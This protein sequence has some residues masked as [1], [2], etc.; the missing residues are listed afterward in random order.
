MGDAEE[1]FV[2]PGGTKYWIPNVPDGFKVEVGMK[3]DSLEAAEGYYVR[4]AHCAGFD[5][6]RSNRKINKLG[7]V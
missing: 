2:S 7:D 5:I 4:Y 3:F 6:R 1:M